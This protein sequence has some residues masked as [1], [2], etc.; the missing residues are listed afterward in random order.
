MKKYHILTTATMV[1]PVYLCWAFMAFGILLEVVGTLAM[2][3]TAGFTRWGPSTLAVL[4]YVA[5]F[6]LFVLAL[7][8][9]PV[10]VAYPTW[11]GVGT[12]L[13]F[14][15]GIAFFQEAVSPVKL[16]SALLVILGVIGL[17]LS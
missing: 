13:I 6:P 9:I 4:C 10:S 15:L 8:K 16:V 11:A 14:L 5:T 17:N 2:K 3:Y 7:K 1:N 12:L